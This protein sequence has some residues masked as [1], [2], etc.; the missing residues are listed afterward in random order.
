MA[1]AQIDRLHFTGNDD[2]DG[3][4]AREPFALLVGFALDQQVTVQTAFAGP[5]KI[6]QRIGTLD[7]RKLAAADPQ[8]LEAAFREKPAVHRFPGSMAQRVHDLAQHITD[9]YGGRAERLWEEAK[10]GADLEARLRGLPGFGDMKVRSTLAVLAKRLGVSLPGLDEL[11]PKH[12][13]L[14]DVDSAQALAD[15]QEKKRAH[16]AKMRATKSG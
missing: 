11:V 10:D 9:E 5:L 12:P 2:A 14:G 7:A 15:Y 4:L 13:T 8:E 16:K 1:T 3:L 6:K